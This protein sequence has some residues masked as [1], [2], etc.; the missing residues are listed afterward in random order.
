MKRTTA[1]ILSLF[2]TASAS[3]AQLPGSETVDG[4]TIAVA[5]ALTLNDCLI[6][7]RRHAH[8]NRISRIRSEATHA[9]KRLAAS[10]LM[11]YVSFGSSASLSFG[12]NI[13]PETNTYDNKKTLGTA[14]GIDFTLPLFDGLVRLNNLKAMQT[15]ATRSDR[16]LRAEEDRVSLEVI[17]NFYNVDYCKAMVAQM[18]RQLQ[19]DSTDLAATIRGE[20]LGTKS[21]A[22]VTELEAVVAADR[23]ELVNQ[24]NLLDK[25]L[26][27]LR[28]S[29]G[30]PLSGEPVSIV[31]DAAA[32]IENNGAY[33]S[34][35]AGEYSDNALI[36]N[37]LPEIEEAELS[38]KESLYYLRAARGGYSPRISLS[39][40]IN[41]SYYRMMGMGAIAE[42]FRRQ[43]RNNMGEYIGLSFSFPIFDGL[44]TANK[45]KRAK[46]NLR[47]SETRLEQKQYEIRKALEEA[48][49]DRDAAIEE[50]TSAEARLKAEMIAYKAMRRKFELGMA[51]AIDLYTSAAKLATAE[52]ALT[53]KR[54]QKV[55]AEIT[56]RYYQGYPLIRLE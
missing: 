24:R 30:M 47:E 12:R 22:D 25:A 26:L 3:A 39:A 1:I 51:S 50:L 48:L 38:V 6:Y 52:A 56:L 31:S 19:R 33:L 44:A 40:G 35:R 43:W 23:F 37:Q 46:L 13:D 18:R 4:D 11:P 45:V 9:D 15:A 10:D 2:I 8:S 28:T 34:D 17:K 41:T 54:I 7:A 21:G 29:M 49:L 16:S 5:E 27:S 32:G 42:S 53:G 36:R 14:F 20:A 55:I